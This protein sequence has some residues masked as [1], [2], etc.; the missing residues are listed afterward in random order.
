[1]TVYGRVSG[2]VRIPDGGLEFGQELAGS[3]FYA[4]ECFSM[5]ARHSRAAA[6]TSSESDSESESVT[7]IE[8]RPGGTH[9]HR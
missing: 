8:H 1:M 4:E 2:T 5:L 7:V 9:G 3:P 6:L